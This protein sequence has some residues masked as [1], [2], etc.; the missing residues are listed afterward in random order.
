MLPPNLD[1]ASSDSSG[2]SP[3]YGQSPS[4]FFG[5]E[6]GS[7]VHSTGQ[8]G[9][10][11]RK[12]LVRDPTG[13]HSIF[14]GLDAAPLPS[15]EHIAVYLE[16]YFQ[17]IQLEYPFLA[18]SVIKQ[19]I[20][21]LSSV[22][23]SPKSAQLPAGYT[24]EDVRF[25]VFL[26]LALGSAVRRTSPISPSSSSERLFYTALR[27]L[28][29][30]NF[31]DNLVGLQNALLLGVAALYID[32]CTS[33]ALIDIWVL[34]AIIAS[35]CFDAELHL[36]P[37]SQV[38]ISEA[39]MGLR[40]RV[41]WSAYNFDKI[42]GKTLRRPFMLSDEDIV[43]SPLDVSDLQD[44]NTESIA[45][46]TI[47]TLFISKL[48]KMISNVRSTL[49]SYHRSAIR[50]ELSEWQLAALRE[51][52]DLRAEAQEALSQFTNRPE[53]AN[54]LTFI[55]S[56]IDIKTH[57]A[58]QFLFRPFDSISYP[59]FLSRR[60]AAPQQ[61][62]KSA[63]EALRL[64]I[65]LAKKGHLTYSWV[66]SQTAFEAGLVMVYALCRD[67]PA[68]SS[69]QGTFQKEFLN[70]SIVL[71]SEFGKKYTSAQ[72][73]CQSLMSWRDQLSSVLDKPATD[74]QTFEVTERISREVLSDLAPSFSETRPPFSPKT[75]QSAGVGGVQGF[76]VEQNWEAGFNWEE[77]LANMTGTETGLGFWGEVGQI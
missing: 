56:L 34:N 51:L 75:P 35:A 23:S 66:T 12:F 58:I 52:H 28:D 13:T 9:I 47:A 4:L 43:V 19:L 73:K 40:Q 32:D 72:G 69:Q 10:S 63:A 22:S 49:H 60:G 77:A 37:N 46:S 57:E 16:R 26:V 7:S 50:E 8:F 39:Q 45:F 15:S 6:T 62:V 1:I 54:H 33:T 65:A 30:V 59:E 14:A 68:W 76:E 36:H 38:A 5:S 27:D 3:L 53:L 11:L 74:Y 64:L 42:V 20:S 29:S 21:I 18:E 24:W 48:V 70:T 17:V 2:L 71:L 41:F 25:Q 67:T 31:S 55:D 61:L 44:G